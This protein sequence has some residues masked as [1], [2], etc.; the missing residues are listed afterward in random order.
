M[1]KDLG[2]EI[3]VIEVNDD[4]EFYNAWMAEGYTFEAP[5]DILDDDEDE[6]EEDEDE[7]ED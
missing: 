4:P 1:Y 7:E 2:E 3:D 5:E 6:V